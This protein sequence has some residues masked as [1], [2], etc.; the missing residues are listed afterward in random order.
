MFASHASLPVQARRGGC[1][2]SSGR[3][4]C[5]RSGQRCRGG[6]PQAPHTPGAEGA[7]G[8]CI[9]QSWCGA[10]YAVHECHVF[11][12]KLDPCMLMTLVIQ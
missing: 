8:R 1:K 2:T 3:A 10:F 12:S 7:L 6:D 11:I 5:R 4:Q 9:G